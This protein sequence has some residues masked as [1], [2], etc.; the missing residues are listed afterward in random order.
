VV[1][2][3]NHNV[4][5]V[6]HCPFSHE[7]VRVYYLYLSKKDRQDV[8]PFSFGDRLVCPFS[9]GDHLIC[10]FSF[11]DR[12]VCPFSFGDRLICPFSFGGRKSLTNFIT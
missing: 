7:H 11:G 2:I 12:L 5:T 3:T 4:F 6:T 9:F 1:V 10:P 8:C